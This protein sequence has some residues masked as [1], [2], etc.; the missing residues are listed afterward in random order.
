MLEEVYGDTAWAVYYQAH[1][2][3]GST[4]SRGEG[5]GTASG[6]QER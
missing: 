3:P 6:S 5:V 1:E 2:Y 4:F